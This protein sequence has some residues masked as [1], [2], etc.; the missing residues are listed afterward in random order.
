MCAVPAHRAEAAASAEV[1]EVV[2]AE[3]VLR[4]V[5]LTRKTSRA[6][7]DDDV[8]PCDPVPALDRVLTSAL[9]GGPGHATDG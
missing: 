8:L 7:V 6:T 1:E 3:Q 2:P 4:R 5:M 9:F